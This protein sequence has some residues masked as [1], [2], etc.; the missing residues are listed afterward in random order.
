[1]GEKQKSTIYILKSEKSTIVVVN[2]KIQ[3]TNL[4]FKEVSSLQSTYCKGL[5]S[6]L[7]S[8]TFFA[9]FST[10]YKQNLGQIYN[11]HLGITHPLFGTQLNLY[12]LIG[13]TKFL[14]YL[15][16]AQLKQLSWALAILVHIGVSHHFCLNTCCS[17][18]IS[19]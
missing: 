10:I 9:Y 14:K 19:I 2:F 4:H 1:M 11:L 15:D 17:K 6:D 5:K 13:I 16:R 12:T 18:M 3:S 7:Q 8:T